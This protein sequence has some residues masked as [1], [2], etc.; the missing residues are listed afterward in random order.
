ML[1]LM[2][3]H[4]E[5]ACLATLV[6]WRI[7]EIPKPQRFNRQISVLCQEL[8]GDILGVSV[9]EKSWFYFLVSGIV[10]GQFVYDQNVERAS[11]RVLGV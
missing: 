9:T 8:S 5:A 6:A 2:R 7:M 10:S 3:V 1:P 11:D 4:T